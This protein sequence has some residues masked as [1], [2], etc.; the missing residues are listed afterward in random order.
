[1][2]PL[3]RHEHWILSDSE[4]V[5]DAD[6]LE[7]FRREWARCDVLTAGYRFS[8]IATWPQ[9]LD[10]A[11]ALLTLWPGLAVLRASG[12]VRSHARRL[13]GISPGDVEAVGGWGAFAD[14]LA[15]DNRLGS[16]A[17]GGGTDD[18]PERA[19]GD[20]RQRP[21]VVARLLAASAPRGGDVSGGES[22]RDLPGRSSRKG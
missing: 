22:R 3:A 5:I 9:R 4:A 2:E 13:H 16:R 15:E 1:M 11:A 12:R 20:A 19:G 17:G 8:R 10:A 14:D 6:F 21:A 18:P 7:A